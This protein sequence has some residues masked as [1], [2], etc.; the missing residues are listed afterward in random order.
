MQSTKDV[1]QEEA[2]NKV[3]KLKQLTG[4]VTVLST[5][6][7]EISELPKGAPVLKRGTL[8][9]D[10]DTKEIKVSDGVTRLDNLSD[11]KH[12]FTHAPLIHSHMFGTNQ[13]WLLSNPKLWYRDDLVNHPELIP[14]EGQLITDDEAVEISKVYPG[15]KLLTHKIDKIENGIFVN[16]RLSL[17]VD[18]FDS[19]FLPSALFEAPLSIEDIVKST[20]QWLTNSTDLNTE[21]WVEIV[22]KDGFTY[23]PMQYWIMPAA[24]TATELD[25]SNPTPKSW[26]IQGYNQE[27][28][29]WEVLDTKTDITDG[30]ENRKFRTFDIESVPN[31]YLKLKLIITEWN[32][33][34]SA[35]MPTGLRRFYVFGREV[36]SYYLPNIETPSDDFVYVIPRENLNTGLKHED[37]GDIGI[38]AVTLPLPTYRL[39][40]DGSAKNKIDYPELFSVL[41]YR[42]DVIKLFAY[43]A[44]SDGTNY[45]INRGWILDTDDVN[46]PAWIEYEL[47]QDLSNDVIGKYAFNTTGFR[48]PKSWIIEG[49][50][51]LSEDFVVLQQFNLNYEDYPVDGNFMID[52][53][54]E[55]SVF[56]YIRITILSWFD[57]GT[58]P[59][60]L[61]GIAFG[62]HLKDQFYLP[63]IT[64]DNGLSYIVARNTADDTSADVIQRLQ[65]NIIDLTHKVISLQNQVNELDPSIIKS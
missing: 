27:T 62:V 15:T 53:I 21:H 12:P 43:T 63:N 2:R 61:L 31:T 5:T 23:K 60:G 34:A 40:T 19:Y 52:T 33:G 4:V 39:L 46:F 44:C 3:K 13:P 22:F 18:M 29:T 36:N 17:H 10:E 14:L 50:N 28:D 51:S 42:Y 1:L 47:P 11:H 32:A 25:K 48:K 7:K 8:I 58:E 49:R 65:Q 57:I 38:T 9:Y 24:G 6:K 64:V 45:D 16:D 37:V 55:D 30:W 35:D 56:K 54:R 26:V 20:D 41:Q 59:L